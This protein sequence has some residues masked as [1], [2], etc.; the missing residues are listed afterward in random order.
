LSGFSELQLTSLHLPLLSLVPGRGALSCSTTIDSL[1]ENSKRLIP[2]R[3]LSNLTMLSF[4][5]TA[6][7]E[8]TYT[9]C[10]VGR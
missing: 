7:S 10:L 2:D 1:I 8:M 5:N 9:L 3:Y 6:A 4:S